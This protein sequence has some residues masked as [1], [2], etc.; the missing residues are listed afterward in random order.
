M[1]YIAASIK[2]DF[3][4]KQGEPPGKVLEKDTQKV[5]LG[6]IVLFPLPIECCPPAVKEVHVVC[7]FTYLLIEH[8]LPPAV[9]V[10]KCCGVCICS[11]NSILCAVTVSL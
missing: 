2:L 9:K 5:C 10:C 3:S 4:R 7:V 11:S 1:E 8:C 6:L